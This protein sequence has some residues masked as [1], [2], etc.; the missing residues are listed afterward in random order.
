MNINATNIIRFPEQ[1]EGAAH[2]V[3]GQPPHEPAEVVEFLPAP[4]DLAFASQA[5]EHGQFFAAHRIAHRV[6]DQ[7]DGVA[8]L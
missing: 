3:V 8:Q 5:Q 7:L 6:A 4:F 1:V 2:R